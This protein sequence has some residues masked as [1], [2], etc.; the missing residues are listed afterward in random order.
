MCELLGFSASAPTR[1]RL[2][3]HEFACQGGETACVRENDGGRGQGAP[4]W[5]SEKGRD[6]NRQT[7][8]MCPIVDAGFLRVTRDGIY[9]H[10]TDTETAHTRTA[11]SSFSPADGNAIAP[12]SVPSTTR[13]G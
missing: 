3:L 11:P 8:L 6:G 12:V 4:G 10:R 1:V 5:T 7:V 13:R 9:A 2:L